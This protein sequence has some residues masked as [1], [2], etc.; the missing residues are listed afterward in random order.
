M[1]LS[2]DN[3]HISLPYCWHR[4]VAVC[5][6]IVT[7]Q[8][9]LFWTFIESINLQS[10]IEINLNFIFML[11]ALFVGIFWCKPDKSIAQPPPFNEYLFKYFMPTNTWTAC[12]RF[13]ASNSPY[14]TGEVVFIIIQCFF[15]LLVNM[16]IFR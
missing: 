1:T 14:T 5:L 11:S 7:R 13:N 4:V 12:Q 6:A 2:T 9:I 10:E 15:Y 16:W 3:I 8:Y